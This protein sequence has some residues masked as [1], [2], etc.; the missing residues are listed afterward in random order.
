MAIQT[1]AVKKVHQLKRVKRANE[2]NTMHK[3]IRHNDVEV[4]S[5][6]V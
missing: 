6:K 1:K 2:K 3:V 5:N 4:T